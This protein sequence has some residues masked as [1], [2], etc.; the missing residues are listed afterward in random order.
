MGSSSIRGFAENR[1]F[2][3]T[4]VL[5]AKKTEPKGSR[6]SRFE[7]NKA[8]PPVADPTTEKILLEWPSGGHNGGCIR[9][10]PEGD[11][12]LSTGDGSGIADEL[13][14]GQDLGDLLG[15][16]LRIDVDHPEGDR[17]YTI[18]KD[19]PFVAT[20]GARGEI[21]SFGHRQAWKF[22]FDRR[23]R[24]WAGEVGQDL[25]EMVY[26]VERG[27]NH[28]WSV[29][30]GRHPFR[31]E[32]K[33][34]PGTFATP[35][36]EHPHS[37]FRSITGGYVYESDRLPKLKG[38]YIYGDY[39]AGKVWSLRVDGGKVID[40]HQLADT[41]IRIVEFAQDEAGEVYLVD[42]A[43]GGFHRLVE[44]PPRAG[45]KPFPHKLSETGLFDST[46]DVRPAPG[47]IPYSVN[48]PLWSDGAQKERFLALPGNSQIEFDAVIYPHG[49]NYADR[50]WRFPDGTILVKTFS[51][52]MEK[53]NPASS[54]RLETRIL[55]HRKMPGNDDE[56]GAQ[57]WFGYTYLWNDE[58]TDAD[59][60]PAEGL[61]RAYTIRDP[62]RAWWHA[63]ANVAIP[64]SDGMH[65]LP[66][67][68][69]EI[70]P[71]RHHAADEQGS[72]LRRDQGEPTRRS[73]TT[74]RLQGAL[75]QPPERL[76]RLVDYQDARADLNLR[77]RAY[78]HANCAHCHRKWGGGNADFDLQA[79]IPLGATKAVNTPPGQG[80]FRLADPRILVPGDPERSLVYQRMKMEGLGRMPHVASSVVDQ[81][82]LTMLR[83]WIIG[84]GERNQIQERGAVNPRVVEEIGP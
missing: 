47:L 56:Y 21:W 61:S 60:L 4:Y 13:A 77:S 42:F 80:A 50:G 54:K 44:A 67:D 63:L 15:A 16:I 52:E 40:H 12:Y 79:S 37:D 71:R 28:G 19:N 8:D 45:T 34:G 55:Q 83:A 38:A 27:G 48:A 5:D 72:R 76:P 11:L 14:T 31:P 51:L 82:A 65:A 2:Y 30:E 69:L 9:F 68:G 43:G 25:W 18:P 46:K 57:F 75:P 49:P 64:Q 7:A 26:L 78:L 17:P 22:G 70:H 81:E 29:N 53:G 74:G 59:L 36:V 3:V 41:Q 73:G 20:P 33:K 58:Q 24:L 10:G 66:H 32:R 35:L 6:L 23:E 39:D 62:G 1:Y 84:L